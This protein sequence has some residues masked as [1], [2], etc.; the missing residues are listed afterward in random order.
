VNPYSGE[1]LGFFVF[2]ESWSGLPF[3]IHTSLL[4]GEIGNELVAW[5]AVFLLVSMATGLYLWWPRKRRVRDAL[6]IRWNTRG[7]KLIFDLH[8]ALSIYS[9]AF[10]LMLA[11]TGIYLMKPNWVDPV[12]AVFSPVEDQEHKTLASSPLGS[13]AAPVSPGQAVALATA[14]FP[15]H[16]LGY[17][18][19]PETVGAPYVVQ[20]RGTRDIDSRYGDTR[21]W[22]DR[23]C[24]RV[25]AAK[26]G[27]NL[28]GGQALQKWML[29]LHT[30]LGMGILGQTLVFLSGMILPG[31][32]VTGL[33]L[34]LRKRRAGKKRRIEKRARITLE[35]LEPLGSVKEVSE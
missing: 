31:L 14:R 7:K 4:M 13:C 8:N 6:S 21:V 5:C 10:V 17:L 30:T 9:F 18:S 19:V 12:I 2:E 29:P 32:F 1:P 25:L 26:D 3:R 24:L 20:L 16:K 33:L 23:N 28:S 11:V 27:A 22:V 34:W 35:A 15:N